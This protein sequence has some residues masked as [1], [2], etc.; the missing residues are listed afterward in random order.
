MTSNDP[1]ELFQAG[2]EPEDIR[3]DVLTSWRRSQFSGVDPEYVDVPFIET[4]FDTQFSRVAT[5][6]MS[7]MAELLVGDSSCLALAD[8]TGSV[9]WRWVSEPMLRHALDDL[10]VSEGFNFGEEFVGTNGLGTALETGALAIVRGSEH[11]VHRFHDVTCVA[12]PVRHPITRRAVG[13]VNVTCR[14]A[15]TNSLLSVV[16]RKL[17]AEIQTALYDRSTGRERQL[18]SAFLHAQRSASGP[19]VVVGDGLFITN[20]EAADL[21]L[22]GL[23]IWDEVR[24]RRGGPDRTS[25]ALPTDLT[26]DVRLVRDGSTP[27]GAVVTLP[28]SSS[29][30]PLAPARR[31][32]RPSTGNSDSDGRLEL[33][34]RAKTL[35]ANAP[36]AVTGEPGTGKVT[37]LRDVLG[38]DAKSL[39][40]S[41]YGLD[42]TEW[43]ASLD[44][45]VGQQPL[46]IR[47]VELLDTSGVRAI[48]SVLETKHGSHLGLTITTAEGAELPS[49]AMLLVDALTAATL[50]VPPLRRTPD[51]M[52]ALAQAELRRHGSTLAFAPDALAALRRHHWPGNIAELVRVVRDAV[53]EVSGDVVGLAA[54]SPN[55]RHANE[56]RALTPLE[57]AEASVI[58]AVLHEHK[59]NKSTAAR[60]LGISRT[61]LYAKIRSYRL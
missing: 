27:A 58:A 52:I 24:S 7:G 9:I 43:L 26:V 20:P 4:D 15:D 17:V 42:P 23:G 2:Q 61:A 48:A 34:A 49:Q 57:H 45:H 54:L 31:L 35:I 11:Y 30:G 3:R 44:T 1:W 33:T 5:P 37:V 18:L 50:P 56:R 12:A 36:L 59:G 60:E 41:T 38:S 19:V 51:A 22:D 6:I 14:A 53:G 25:L 16:V 55:V 13:A 21:G 29:T 32:Q 39:D 8:A 10:S 47:H 40:A 46:V 28:S